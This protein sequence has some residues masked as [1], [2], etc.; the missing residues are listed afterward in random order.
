MFY[1][2]IIL[3]QAS[4]SGYVVADLVTKTQELKDAKWLFCYDSGLREGGLEPEQVYVRHVR[5]IE[6]VLKTWKRL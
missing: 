1:D 4:A 2:A 5:G 3:S 6:T